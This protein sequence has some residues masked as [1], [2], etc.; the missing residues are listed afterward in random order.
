MEPEALQSSCL[1]D[2][3]PWILDIHERDFGIA[4]VLASDDITSPARGLLGRG[5]HLKGWGRVLNDILAR[6]LS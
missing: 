3:G 4:A 6:P 5:E 1:T 2:C